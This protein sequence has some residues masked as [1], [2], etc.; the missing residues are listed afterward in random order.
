MWKGCGISST[1][2]RLFLYSWVK[3]LFNTYAQL[4][5]CS[6]LHT[7][8]DLCDQRVSALKPGSWKRDEFAGRLTRYTFSVEEDPTLSATSLH[9]RSTR[10]GWLPRSH[11]ISI[12]T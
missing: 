10:R 3:A 2:S 11:L 12:L 4:G 8:E 1:R 7:K 9:I 6:M 5:L